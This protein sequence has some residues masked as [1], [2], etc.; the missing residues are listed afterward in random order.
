MTTIYNVDN[1]VQGV[2]GFG[3]PHCSQIFTVTLAAAT[4]ATVAVPLSAGVGLPTANVNNKFIA[5]FSYTALDVWVS[6]NSL[7]AVPAGAN[8]AQS[9]S[10]LCPIA[11]YCMAGD[12]IHMI[13]GATPSVSV[14]FYAL[15]D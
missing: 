4:E 14:A 8:F 1:F 12:V 10:E 9:T 3:L 2:N 5:V 15:V 13:S 6:V 11:K 7:A